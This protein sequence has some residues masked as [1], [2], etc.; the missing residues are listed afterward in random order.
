MT[1]ET[2]T[3]GSKIDRDGI[4]SEI[5]NESLYCA[6]CDYWQDDNPHEPDEKENL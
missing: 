5:Q 4:P 3:I 2:Y 6:H 1:L